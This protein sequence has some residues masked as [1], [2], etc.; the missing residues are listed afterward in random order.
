M[1]AIILA[2]VNWILMFIIGFSIANVLFHRKIR[3]ILEEIKV[4]NKRLEEKNPEKLDD[5]KNGF[6]MGKLDV[7]SKLTE[8][9]LIY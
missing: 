4:E 8:K 1:T 5:Y 9:F 3:R 7:I 6:I 2:F